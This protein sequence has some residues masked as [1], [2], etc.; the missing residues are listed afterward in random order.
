[1]L[2]NLVQLEHIVGDKTYRFFCEQTSPISEIK[3]ALCQFM[4]YVGNIEDQIKARQE[5]EK[6]EEN[7]EVKSDIFPIEKAE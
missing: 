1:M 2:K 4:K 5:E 6:S 7:K 3:D